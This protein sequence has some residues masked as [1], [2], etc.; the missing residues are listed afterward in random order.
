MLGNKMV[1]R[2]AGGLTAAAA[3]ANH[4]EDKLGTVDRA[5]RERN[6]FTALVKMPEEVQ[7]VFLENGWIGKNGIDDGSGEYIHGSRIKI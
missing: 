7:T 6:I 1:P 3:T 4:G 2:P 5:I